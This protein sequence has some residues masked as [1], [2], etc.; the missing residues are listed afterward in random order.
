MI[1]SLDKI[2]G[3]LKI[4]KEKNSRSGRGK[5]RGRKTRTSKGLIIITGNDEKMKTDMVDNVKVKE[6]IVSDLYPSGR[7]AVYTEKAIKDL[8]DLYKN[9]GKK[10]K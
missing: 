1:N 7:I 5:L 8:E 2:L 9:S 6:L 10:E 3:E 4:L